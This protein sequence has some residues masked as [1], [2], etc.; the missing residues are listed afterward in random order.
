MR[1]HR[2]LPVLLMIPLLFLAP[3]CG[4]AQEGEGPPKEDQLLQEARREASKAIE[5]A[6]LQLQGAPPG[7]D[8]SDARELL[9]QA[10][11][12]FDQAASTEQLTGKGG[13]VL[14]LVEEAKRSARAAMEARGGQ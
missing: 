6:E 13:S 3:S 2:F 4:K 10:R 8:L 1:R 5:D 12:L 9:D 11:A 14:E 7:T